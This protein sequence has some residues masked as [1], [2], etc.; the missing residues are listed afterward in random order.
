VSVSVPNPYIIHHH[1]VVATNTAPTD[2]GNVSFW[3]PFMADFNQ[4]FP[5]FC[6]TRSCMLALKSTPMHG[7]VVVVDPV[8]KVFRLAHAPMQSSSL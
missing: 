5:P 1:V 6:W 8:V 7:V 2:G 3:A 4:Q